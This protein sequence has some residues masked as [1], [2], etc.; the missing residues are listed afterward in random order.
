[1]VLKAKTRLISVG[2]LQ[3]T[4]GTTYS[5]PAKGKVDSLGIGTATLRGCSPPHGPERK[6]GLRFAFSSRQLQNGY[7]IFERFFSG[8]YFQHVRTGG[9]GGIRTHRVR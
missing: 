9:E 6:Q 1:V 5:V 8:V 3:A 2:R 4:V 7:K